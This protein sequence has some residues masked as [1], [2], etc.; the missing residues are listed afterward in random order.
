M[1]DDPTNYTLGY[2]YIDECLGI[3]LDFE[4][5]FYADRDLKPKDIV[6]L[7]FSFKHLGSYYSSNLAVDHMQRQ[8][9]QWDAG[10]VDDKEFK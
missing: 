6:T 10:S 5:S 2:Q 9:I 3:N 4:R 7:M 8:N 1:K